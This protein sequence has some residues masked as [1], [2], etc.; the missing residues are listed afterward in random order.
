V[1]LLNTVQMDFWKS[2]F[3]E[4]Y[5]ERNTYSVNELDS[6][7]KQQYGYTRSEMNKAFIKEIAVKRTLEVG[8]N[9]GN[10]LLNLQSIGLECLYGIELQHYAVERSKIRC[11]GINIIQG[12]AFDIPYK[13][14]YF[15]LVFTSG[16]L[17]HLSP[18]DIKVAIDEMHRVSNKYIWGFEYYADQYMEIEYHGNGN[19]MWK[20]NFA[21]LF[22]DRFDN[23]RLVKEKK[24]PY[25][26]NGNVDH[27]Y[28]LEKIE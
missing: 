16:V 27:M 3:G 11:Q 7:Y 6:I 24:Y 1:I 20:T 15:D 19:R 23:L 22:L 17:I 12:S 13:N 18:E 9:V 28:L 2:K 25:L 5:T 21:Q 8:C 4:D 10:I 26:K 14:N